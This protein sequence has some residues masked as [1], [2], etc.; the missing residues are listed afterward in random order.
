MGSQEEER[1]TLSELIATVD[2]SHKTSLIQIITSDRIPNIVLDWALETISKVN[3]L[4]YFP[5][6]FNIQ[7][8]SQQDCGSKKM[9]LGLNLFWEVQFDFLHIF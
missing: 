3:L 8:L 4:G 2:T 9:P 6:P 1:S 5:F 7:P